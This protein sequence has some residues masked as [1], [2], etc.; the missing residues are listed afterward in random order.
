MSIL[1]W[2]TY[3]SAHACVGLSPGIVE[4]IQRRAR[5]D[6]PVAMIPNGCDN[7]LFTESAQVACRPEG[8]ADEDLMAVF[9]GTHGIANGLDAVLETAAELVDRG[10]DDIKLV[11]IGD[12]RLKSELVAEAERRNLKN[13]VFVDPVPKTDLVGYLR[14]ADLGLM[15]L[16]NVRAF[17][18]GTSP[19][20]FFDYLS[21]GL[22]VL[23]NYPG[24]L[25]GIITD[26]DI[27]YAVPAEDPKAFAN[28]LEDAADH[29]ETLIEMGQRAQELAKTEFAREKLASEFVEF[30]VG[31]F[32]PK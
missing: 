17:Y 2:T 8:V 13:C 31:H 28:A 4:G 14:A 1:E 15:I 11:F 29:R 23:N 12:G 19:N 21:V 7:Q 9:T 10:R 5:S 20:K 32:G 24:W 26:N 16:A 30:L 6:L 3:R 18:H 25:A 27:G 22:P